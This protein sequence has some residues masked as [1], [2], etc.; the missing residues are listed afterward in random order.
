M[1]T[2]W[3]R[4]L[5]ALATA[6][7]VVGSVSASASKEGDGDAPRGRNGKGGDGAGFDGQI[8]VPSAFARGSAFL[9]IGDEDCRMLYPR[10]VGMA[11]DTRDVE[12]R[13]SGVETSR[14]P[15]ACAQSNGQVICKIFIDGFTLA[16]RAAVKTDTAKELSFGTAGGYIDTVIDLKE[17]TATFKQT[18]PSGR[19]TVCKASYK[20]REDATEDVAKLDPAPNAGLPAKNR[21][22][23]MSSGGDR[24]TCMSRHASR[25]PKDPL[26]ERRA[27]IC[28]P[29]KDTCF[30]RGEDCKAGVCVVTEA[31]IARD[32]A[33]SPSASGSTNGGGK[34][35][36]GKRLGQS[37]KTTSECEEGRVCS[38]RTARLRTCQ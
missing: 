23:G 37:C 15:I 38:Q 30:F 3:S 27:P 25:A 12:E 28:S 33:D 7:A 8:Q 14:F 2:G 1:G 19:S 10:W 31:A 11:E 34:K 4:K 24:L 17:R 13:A 32:W 5:A 6:A 20:S 21:P 22:N 36:R 29:C 9:L 26:T 35:K 18:A 16:F